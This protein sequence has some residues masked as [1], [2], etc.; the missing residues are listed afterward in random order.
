M[1]ANGEHQTSIRQQAELCVVVCAMAK[2]KANCVV[3]KVKL[4]KFCTVIKGSSRSPSVGCNT[5]RREEGAGGVSCVSH[6]M[7]QTF[8]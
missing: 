8:A 6:T 4:L 3:V 1:A 7:R 5:L 2:L